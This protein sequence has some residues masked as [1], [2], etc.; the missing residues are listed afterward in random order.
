MFCFLCPVPCISTWMWQIFHPGHTNGPW[1]C[2]EQILDIV[3]LIYITSFS[4]KEKHVC[5][6]YNQNISLTTN[7]IRIEVSYFFFV[8]TFVLQ[9]V[10]PLLTIP[11]MFLLAPRLVPASPWSVRA[12][13]RSPHWPSHSQP[14]S[15]WAWQPGL[16][17]ALM[18][19]WEQSWRWRE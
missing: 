4:T 15:R 8:V 10:T 18:I 12:R 17:R 14:A 5:F 11:R 7:L 16:V 6:L 2:Q 13:V 1:K 19:R 9:E 3:N